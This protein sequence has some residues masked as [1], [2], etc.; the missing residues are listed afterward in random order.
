VELR[1][2]DFERAEADGQSELQVLD[3]VRA[4]GLPVSA[5]GVGAGWM[6]ARGSERAQL[7][8]IFTRSC[9]AAVSLDCA[10]VMSPVDRDAGDSRQAAASVREVGETA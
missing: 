6:F 4:S 9:L 10:I 8:D 2:L 5:V 7:L 3:L 1:R